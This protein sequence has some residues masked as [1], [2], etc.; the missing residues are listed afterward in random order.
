MST[1]PVVDLAT[2]AEDGAWDEN[3]FGTPQV[4]LQRLQSRS[5]DGISAGARHLPAAAVASFSAF[6]DRFDDM[7]DSE[8]S[9]DTHSERSYQEDEDLI[10]SR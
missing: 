5:N 8:A 4:P 10:H 3:A 2:I 6:E 7:S 1:R 9:S